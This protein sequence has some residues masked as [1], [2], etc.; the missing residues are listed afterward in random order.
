MEASATTENIYARGDL[1]KKLQGWGLV[2]GWVFVCV[3]GGLGY[4]GNFIDNCDLLNKSKG[5][6]LHIYNIE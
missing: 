6:S 1:F 3:Y 2:S 5:S 4:K